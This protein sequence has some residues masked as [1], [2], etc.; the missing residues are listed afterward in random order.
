M[1]RGER[2]PT[3]GGDNAPPQQAK[4]GKA[5]TQGR[6]NN[7][8]KVQGKKIE[9]ISRGGKRRSKAP[10][11][12]FPM[13]PPW[14][15][16]PHMLPPP[17]TIHPMWTMPPPAHILQRMLPAAGAQAAAAAEAFTV[18]PRQTK[19]HRP[20]DPD[21]DAVWAHDMFDASQARPVR[22]AAPTVVGTKLRISNLFHGVS[23]DDI[24][25]LFGT[26]GELLSSNI[27]YDTSGRS[28]GEATVVYRNRSD[29]LKAIQEYNEILL[30]GQELRIE[31]VKAREI[32]KLSSGISVTKEDDRT[33]PRA[34]LTSQQGGVRIM[35]QALAS[36]ELAAPLPRGIRGM[37][38]PSPYSAPVQPGRRGQGPGPRVGGRMKSGV[39][40]PFADDMQE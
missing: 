14:M 37:G 7:E 1:G 36:Q 31:E 38:D 29:A 32:T 39:S 40:V 27:H 11:M 22:R 24:K 8:I 33:L 15:V 9:K 34:A 2:R 21:A 18:P 4:Q 5:V 26:V 3:R 19:Q 12:P 17:G 13:M 28:K 16:P 35:Q 25:E 10:A 20:R 30:D 6:R 23:E